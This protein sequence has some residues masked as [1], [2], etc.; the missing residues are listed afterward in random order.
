MAP[1]QP[2]ISPVPAPAV[3]APKPA[4]T[5]AAK[6]PAVNN[7]ENLSKSPIPQEFLDKTPTKTVAEVAKVKAP[8]ASPAKPK[9]RRGVHPA[10]PFLGA[11]LLIVGVLVGLVILKRKDSDV[12][13]PPVAAVAAVAAVADVADVADVGSNPQVDESRNRFLRDGWK[14]YSSNTLVG[15]LRARSPEEKARHVLGGEE[16]L[17]T[18]REFY[19]NEQEVDDSDTPIEAFSHFDLDIADKKRGLFLMQYERPAQYD[20]REFFRP[21]APLEIQHRLEEPDLLLSAFAARENFAMQPVRVMA[22]FKE[23]DNKLL[24]DWDVYTQT[25]YRTLRHFATYPQPGVSRVFRVMV[26]EVLPASQGVDGLRHR[27]FRFSDPAHAQDNVDVVVAVETAP[28]RIL[29]E[30]A[31]I[32][33]PDREA[34]NRYATV[35][36]AWT[37][38][39]HPQV[40]LRKVICWEF[41]GLGGVAG[42][43]DPIGEGIPDNLPLEL[44]VLE[45]DPLPPAPP[46]STPGASEAVSTEEGDLEPPA[47]ETP[48]GPEGDVEPGG[49]G[50]GESAE[51]AADP[52]NPATP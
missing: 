50:E 6:E 44:G 25:K 33:L 15:F 5:A 27:Y 9:A 35:E 1:P 47:E 46:A 3:E 26:R 7:L 30:L 28:G 22:F 34:Q 39:E 37:R 42:N 12:A 40:I 31:W 38:E 19:L 8:D 4:E 51:P 24:L 21:V 49:E 13:D 29:F 16:R 23:V 20:I 36:L 32:N 14:T 41:L 45:P 18:M 17:A 43:A 11:I 2:Q 52:E 10:I 48:P